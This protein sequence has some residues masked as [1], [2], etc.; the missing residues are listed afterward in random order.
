[1]WLKRLEVKNLRNLAED[2]IGFEN[3]FNWLVGPNGQ[4]KTNCLEAV[5]F[6]LTGKSF[7]T[8]RL[9]DLV[10]QSSQSSHVLCDLVKKNHSLKFGVVVEQGKSKRYLGD[11][12][13]KADA[14][15]RNG[16]V[17]AFT[18]RSKN[19][20]DGSPEDRRRFLDR[21]ICYLDP[22]HLN[23]LGRYRQIMG[24]IKKIIHQR[25]DLAL[26]KSFKTAAVPIA[27]SLAGVRLRFLESVLGRAQSIYSEVFDGQEQL[28]VSYRLR[29]C[30]SLEKLEQRMMDLSS[31]ELLHGRSMIGPHLDDLDIRIKVKKAKCYASSGQVRAIVLSMKL[32]V[33]ELF[34]EKKDCFPILLLDDID[35]ELD[36]LRLE[37]LM[38]YL[39]NR[40]QTLITTSKYGIINTSRTGKVFQVKAGR[41]SSERNSG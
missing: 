7:R 22:D 40:G 13:V 17:M 3:G 1:M 5:Y 23:L 8:T 2:A 30:G 20:V 28:S 4:G 34:F 25:S 32:A 24:Q 12:A 27:S 37:K 11:K 15:F 31:Q 14:F 18:S 21:M 16:A 6:V 38:D 29:N 33:R 19:L 36:S 9:N 39:S 35:S 41:I 26:L 10:Q